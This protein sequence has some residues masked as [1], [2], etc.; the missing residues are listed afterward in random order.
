MATSGNVKKLYVS[1]AGVHT[2]IGGEVSSNLSSSTN[3]ID[4]SSKDSNWVT[5]IGGSSS[6]N[7]SASFVAEDNPSS[8]Q[9]KLWDAMIEGT[10]VTLFWGTIING[11]ARGKIG[12]ALI[13]NV[14]ETADRDGVV[15]KDITFEGT[16]A[17]AR[18]TT[19]T[20]GA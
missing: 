18:A 7:G 15:T 8:E 9:E 12:Q 2:A 16:G 17:L 14:D 5:K 3:T 19:T 11:V 6:F 13:T 10:I 4:T 1:V 20:T